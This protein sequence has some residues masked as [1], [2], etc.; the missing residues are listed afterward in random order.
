MSSTTHT[1]SAGALVCHD[2]RLLLVRHVRPGRYDFRVP[3]GGQVEAAES[4]EDA[5]VRECLEETGLRVEQP[6]LAYVEEFHC[7][8]RRY[9]KFW[10]ACTLVGG[11]L[12][13]AHPS[14]QVEHIVDAGWFTREA[15]ATET[16]Q[17]PFLAERYW[18]DREAGFPSI[19]RMPLRAMVY[20]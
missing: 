7:P 9:V 3:P 12:S 1:I 20:W 13:I 16:V 10:F 6:R 18:S 11:E 15:M 2:D 17:P 5:A 19:V 4:L 8:G 14:T